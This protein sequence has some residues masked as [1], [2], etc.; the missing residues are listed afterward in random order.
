M[1]STQKIKEPFI[2]SLG[3]LIAGIITI[4][5]AGSASGVDVNSYQ[6]LQMSFI[7]FVLRF[8]WLYILRNYFEGRNGI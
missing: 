3:I 4:P 1:V 6:A 5:L 2:G 7:F 8:F